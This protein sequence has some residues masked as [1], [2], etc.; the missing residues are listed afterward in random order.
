ME[1]TVIEE[2]DP[3]AFYHLLH[4]RDGLTL[5]T[6]KVLTRANWT[7]ECKEMSNQ[8]KEANAAASDSQRKLQE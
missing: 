8:I 3:S 5:L 6:E 7:K 1:Q 2:E 4:I